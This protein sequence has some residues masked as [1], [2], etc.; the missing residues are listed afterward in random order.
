MPKSAGSDLKMV[1]GAPSRP[2]APVRSIMH[3]S[4]PPI[5]RGKM[6]AS[7]TAPSGDPKIAAD[8]KKSGSGSVDPRQQVY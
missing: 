8:V 6:P 7:A 4:P 2:A 5:D 1:R 3:Q